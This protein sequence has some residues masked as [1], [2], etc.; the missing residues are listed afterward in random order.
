MQ[1]ENEQEQ[2][3]PELD[4]SSISFGDLA[5]AHAAISKQPKNRAPSLAP[6]KELPPKK[7]V[8]SK[9]ARTEPLKRSS[10][11]APIE[12][13]SKKPVSRKRDIISDTKP[14]PRDPRFDP[15]SGPLDEGKFKRAYAFLDSYRDDEIKK[16]R[17]ALRKAKSGD[18]KEGLKR[19]L[20]SLEGRRDTERKKAEEQRV[21]EEHKKQEKELVKQ[22]KQPFYLK[23]AEQKRRLLAERFKKMNKGQVEKAIVKKRKK[24]ATKD[25]IALE[26][27]E[28]A[29]GART[30][31]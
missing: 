14:K 18:E 16:L 30:R 8:P 24:E 22:G 12:M 2:K 19:Q 21:L 31:R 10:K 1:T 29:T 26:E 4:L 25:R 27:V 3:N 23:K 17:E 7:P 11:H 9:P 13:S 28:R 20:K 6:T 15:I 5:K